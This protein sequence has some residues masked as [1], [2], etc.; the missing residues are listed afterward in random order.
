MNDFE[1]LM[2]E[3]M[4]PEYDEL[5]MLLG[6]DR[7]PWEPTAGKS[8]IGKTRRSPQERSFDVAIKAVREGNF[9]TL[10]RLIKSPRE[11]NWY[12]TDKAWCL[13]DDAVKS[14]SPAMVQW[15]LNE[16]ANPNTLF[17]YDKPYDFRKGI[18]PGWYFSPF[19]TAM[20]SKNEGMISL[21]LAHGADLNLPV[22][23]ESPEDNTTCRDVAVADGFWPSVEAIVI[24]QSLPSSQAG[25]T[26]RL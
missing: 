9:A 19:A 10:G 12:A 16:G 6:S 20:K 2:A 13:L 11:A 7:T 17:R 8:S 21:M 3:L 25:K 1:K 18:V 4:G 22:I 26:K 14:G 15:L 5:M 23:W 24:A